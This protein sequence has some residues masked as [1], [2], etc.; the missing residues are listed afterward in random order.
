MFESSLAHQHSLTIQSSNGKGRFL[1]SLNI[2]SN[3]G[4]VKGSKDTYKR[5]TGQ[6]NADY[7][8]YK[9]LN[10]TTNTSFENKSSGI[11]FSQNPLSDSKSI[12]G[13]S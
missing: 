3:H 4:I 13:F 6:I 9:W 11:L 12:T 5:F 10:V 8:I 7:D 2:L 1:A